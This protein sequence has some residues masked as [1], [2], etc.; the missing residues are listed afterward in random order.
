MQMKPSTA[1]EK[2]IAVDGITGSAQKNIEAAAKYIRYLVKT[3]VDRPRFQI[4][5]KGIDN[6]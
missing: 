4:N 2:E 5:V 3:Y 6:S 1:R